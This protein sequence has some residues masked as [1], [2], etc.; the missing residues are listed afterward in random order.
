LDPQLFYK[1]KSSLVKS[2][3][4]EKLA[5][6]HLTFAFLEKGGIFKLIDYIKTRCYF[7]AVFLPDREEIKN[8]LVEHKP[9]ILKRITS[10]LK[11]QFTSKDLW[12][13]T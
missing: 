1:S 11:Y 13:Y 3:G 2:L 9:S 6:H 8:R 4:N 12:W 7:S 10:K 5:G